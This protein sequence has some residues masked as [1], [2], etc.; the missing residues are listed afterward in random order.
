MRSE[1]KSDKRSILYIDP[2]SGVSG[3]MLLGAFLDL[4]VSLK[5][6]ASAVESVIPGEVELTAHEVTRSGLA[7]IACDVSIV[8]G[9]Q[10]RN[11]DEMMNL[12]KGSGLTDLVVQSSLRILESLGEAE[13]KAHGQAKG[14]I[15]LHELGG[16]DTLADIVGSLAAVYSLEADHVR[17]GAV[18]LGRGFVQ[19]DHGQ[20]PVPAPA[21]ARLVENMPVFSKGP[22][23]ELTT[24]TGAAI[25]REIVKDFGPIDPMTV[26]RSGNGAGTREFKR[27]PNLLRIF[28]GTSLLDEAINSAV[29][30]ESF[31]TTHQLHRSLVSCCP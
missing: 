18:N 2:F 30:I 27:F 25:L 1:I 12:V 21:T 22:E 23:S 24:P 10:R 15:H 17:C 29:I 14:P 7:G 20:M 3:D 6:I 28:Y 19:T 26:Q 13:G 4:G 16:Q 5:V 31:R 9:P 8:G 11:L